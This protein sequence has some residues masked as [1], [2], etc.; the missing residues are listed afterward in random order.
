MSIANISEMLNTKTFCYF[1]W[2][3]KQINFYK[4]Q[5][6]SIP[7]CVLKSAWKYADCTVVVPCYI[8]EIFAYSG[9]LISIVVV[10]LTYL[11]EIVELLELLYDDF[12]FPAIHDCSKSK[13]NRI[14]SKTEQSSLSG[15]EIFVCELLMAEC[16]CKLVLVAKCSHL[17]SYGRW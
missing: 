17:K 15:L 5:K 10:Q 9:S 3:F 14:W 2:L 4:T 6:W 1:F 11:W 7:K 12:F 13:F 8:T 16:F